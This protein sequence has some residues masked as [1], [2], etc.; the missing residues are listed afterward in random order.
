MGWFSD[1]LENAYKSVT[2]TVK[3]T[4]KSPEDIALNVATLGQYGR[5]KAGV[6]FGG[7]EASDYAYRNGGKTAENVMKQGML[8]L[9]AKQSAD[10][11]AKLDRD[12]AAAGSVYSGAGGSADP[13]GSLAS[14]STPNS[15]TKKKS[16][17]GGL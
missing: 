8:A 13:F 1:A 3:E 5:I 10:A 15:M 4:V 11:R 7:A 12:T 14:S 6:K 2:K 17:L 9:D 16:I